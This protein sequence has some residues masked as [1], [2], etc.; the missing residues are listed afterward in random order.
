Q[1]LKEEA[2]SRVEKDERKKNQ[3]DF[4]LW[5][6]AGESHLMKWESPWGVGY[7]GWHLECSVM[8][9][10]YL[11]D[12]FDIHAGGK[13][14]IFPHHPNERAQ[15]RAATGEGQARYWLH[16][17]FITWEGEK[18]SKSKGNFVTVRE[19]LDEFSGDTIRLYILSSHYRSETDFSKEGLEKAEKELETARRAY[20]RARENTG[21]GS[22]D[23]SDVEKDFREFMDDDLNTAKAK[24]RLMEFANDVN[25]AIDAGEE[26]PG[27]APEKLEELF[28]VL[29][30]SLESTAT[31]DESSMADLL[32]D[33]RQE[34]R[35]SEDYETAD[36]IRSRL[37]DLGFDVEDTDEGAEW[38]KVE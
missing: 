30:I 37:E 27:E 5:L 18:M 6:D 9:Q 25:S 38:F 2:E 4:A 3:Y 13:D 24:Q 8:G 29:G 19:L 33:L 12:E 34:F 14:H 35:E 17:E 28:Q 1:E 22:L 7:P 31:Q 36:L 26:V 23:V 20:Q 15:C 21:E 32:L 16:C 11:G 10:K